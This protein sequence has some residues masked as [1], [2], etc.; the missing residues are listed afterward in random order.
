MYKLLQIIKGKLMTVKL[1]K[2]ESRDFLVFN[3]S[4]LLTCKKL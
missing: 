4:Q 3:F 2:T 1:K